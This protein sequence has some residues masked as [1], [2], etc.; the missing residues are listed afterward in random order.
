MKEKNSKMQ[1]NKK[2]EEE[3]RHKKK[4]SVLR[5]DQRKIVHMNERNL[6][7]SKSCFVREQKEKLL[8]LTHGKKSCIASLLR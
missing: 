4:Q 3:Q 6:K 2:R 1:T 5:T 7:H 8:F